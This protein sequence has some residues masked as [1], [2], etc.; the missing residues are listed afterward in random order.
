MHNPQHL[1]HQKLNPFP[2]IRQRRRLLISEDGR[3]MV[4]SLRL[5]TV[6]TGIEIAAAVVAVAGPATGFADEV[7]GAVVGFADAFA[8]S[9]DHCIA[10][11]VG[12]R[13]GWVVLVEEVDG[14]G[15]EVPGQALRQASMCG[16]EATASG[17]ARM[18]VLR[19]L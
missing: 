2:L 8:G 6:T 11:D 9:E 16:Q 7:V 18:R 13:F 3:A 15:W 19:S 10:G 4:R 12:T 17:K 14:M 1:L 5:T